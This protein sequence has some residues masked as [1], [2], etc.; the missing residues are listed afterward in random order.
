MRS[1][2]CPPSLFYSC[3]LLI[4][5]LMVWL[6]RS[7]TSREQHSTVARSL[8]VGE[9]D[10]TS[11]SDSARA[12]RGFRYYIPFVLRSVQMYSELVWLWH[13]SIPLWWLGTQSRSLWMQIWFC[14]QSYLTSIPAHLK[15]CLATVIHNVKW[16]EGTHICVIWDQTFYLK[17]LDVFIPEAIEPSPQML[18][19]RE[20]EYLV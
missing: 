2:L 6:S 15:L 7:L 20:N 14:S 1:L 13:V 11:R 3:F 5:R 4:N 17:I 9:S 18:H 10:L 8:R 19:S 16:V 12:S